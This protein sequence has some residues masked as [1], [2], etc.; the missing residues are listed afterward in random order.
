MISLA[1]L[2][3]RSGLDEPT[4]DGTRLRRVTFPCNDV[5]LTPRVDDE[6]PCAQLQEPFS[7]LRQ[8]A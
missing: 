1:W 4:A 2:E 3:M 5:W 8:Q 6:D 7:T